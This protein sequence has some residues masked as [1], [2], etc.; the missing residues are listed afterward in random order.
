MCDLTRCVAWPPMLLK[1][2]IIVTG[3]KSGPQRPGQ[4]KPCRS[5]RGTDSALTVLRTQ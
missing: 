3:K 2:L 5:G 1:L 4:V